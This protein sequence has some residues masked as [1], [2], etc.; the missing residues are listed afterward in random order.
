MLWV[1]FVLEGPS[2]RVYFAGDTGYFNGFEA[3]GQ[4]LGPFDLVAVPIGAYEPRAMMRESHMNPEEALRAAIDLRA[5][6][7]M[8]MHYGTFDLSD[9]PLAEPPLRF[10]DAA[11][12]SE[13]G[14]E[15]AWVLDIGETRKF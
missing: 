5:S 7:A 10:R 11:I 14:E 1:G 12:N 2:G 15:A 6:R 8:A 9:E 3:I 4:R 13:L